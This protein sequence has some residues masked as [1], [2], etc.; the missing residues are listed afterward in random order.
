MIHEELED[1]SVV[2]S[3]DMPRAKGMTVGESKSADVVSLSRDEAESKETKSEHRQGNRFQKIINSVRALLPDRK[4]KLNNSKEVD[5]T[6]TPTPDTPKLLQKRHQ[7]DAEN[8]T[9]YYLKPTGH[10]S[11][12]LKPTNSLTLEGTQ[13]TDTQKKS[14]C[15][16]FTKKPVLHKRRQHNTGFSNGNGI[17][18]SSHAPHPPVSPCPETTR[19]RNLRTT[20]HT[21][22]PIYKWFKGSLLYQHYTK[23]TWFQLQ[24]YFLAF[25]FAKSYF[26]CKKKIQ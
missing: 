12:E 20:T 14:Y 17:S 5:R 13:M 23:C 26:L 2:R 15:F 16:P 11:E 10:L 6:Q 9:H 24:Y 7:N 4:Q 19:V 8:N 22:K 25:Y 1:N 21:L 18:S 3:K